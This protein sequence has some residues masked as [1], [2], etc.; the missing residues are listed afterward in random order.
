MQGQHFRESGL[1][2]VVIN[3]TAKGREIFKMKT[4]IELEKGRSGI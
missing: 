2:L 1:F 3:L 4:N